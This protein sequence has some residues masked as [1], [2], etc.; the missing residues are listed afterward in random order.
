MADVPWCPPGLK[1][2]TR[3]DPQTDCRY[4]V[5]EEIVEGSALLLCWPWPLADERGRLFWPEDD[6]L[7]PGEASIDV[8]VLREELYR[9]SKVERAP[10]VGDTFAVERIDDARWNDPEPV[11]HVRELFP[12]VVFDVSAEA[13]LAAKLAYAGSLM[14]PVARQELDADIVEEAAKERARIR[15]RRLHAQ[16]RQTAA[17]GGGR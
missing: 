12:G 10:R 16:E 8:E 17:G 7:E 2:F 3:G 11:P 13:R 14:S 9:P 1:Q 6:D 4:V 15:P 5:L